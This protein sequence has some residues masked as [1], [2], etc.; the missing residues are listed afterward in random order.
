MNWNYIAG[1]FDADG[2]ISVIKVNKNKN[3]TLQVSFHNNEVYILDQIRYFILKELKIMGTISLKPAKKE[4]HSDS[5]ELKYSYQN[6]LRVANK[7]NILHKKKKYR[8]DI[9][10][11]IQ[12]K[13]KRNGK[14]SEKELKERENLL[15]KFLKH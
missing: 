12:E 10:N 11:Q 4:T 7:L 15:E 5:Y 1:F 2:S 9:Y 3:K 6:A 14:Y 13:T 8:I